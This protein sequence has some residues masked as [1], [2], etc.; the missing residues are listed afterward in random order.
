MDW[1]SIKSV[2]MCKY[3]AC[4]EAVDSAESMWC[5]SAHLFVGCVLGV[6]GDGGEGLSKYL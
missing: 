6:F 2:C 3:Q 5:P 4:S 1:S